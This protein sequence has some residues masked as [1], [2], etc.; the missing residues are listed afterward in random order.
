MGFLTSMWCPCLSLRQSPG[1]A[2]KSCNQDGL[3]GHICTPHVCYF[4]SHVQHSKRT[5]VPP[6]EWAPTA[7]SYRAGSFTATLEISHS[8]SQ[9]VPALSI[10]VGNQAQT[11]GPSSQK[12]H[13]ISFH[14]AKKIKFKNISGKKTQT[15]KQQ[16]QE[17]NPNPTGLCQLAQYLFWLVQK[18]SLLKLRFNSLFILVFIYSVPSFPWLYQDVLA[19]PLFTCF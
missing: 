15:N 14:A 5:S 11:L 19:A 6:M 17:Q 8:G 16:Q 4:S 2:V 18:F 10:W 3:H 7:S 12:L 1:C 13:V 9:C